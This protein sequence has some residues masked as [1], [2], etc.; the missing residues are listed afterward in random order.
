MATHYTY[1]EL[2]KGRLCQGDVL[3][4]TP[5]LVSLLKKYHSHYADHPDYRYFLVLTQ[6]CDLYRRNGS[7]PASRYITLA[8]VRP[9]EEAIRREARSRQ[10]WWQEPTRVLSLRAFDELVLFTESL[11]NNNIPNYFY[12]HED[13]SLGIS[14][15]HCAFL[16]LSVALKIDHYDLC[17]DSKLAQLKEPFQAKLGWLVGNMYSRIGTEEW[18]DH[19]G[20]ND[21]RKEA[22]ALLK[23][24]FV[25]YRGEQIEKAI[26]SLRSQQKLEEYSPNEILEEVQRCRLIPPQKEFGKRVEAIVEGFRL[27]D[28]VGSRTMEAIRTDERLALQVR[29]LLE[30]ADVADAEAV[31][32]EVLTSISKWVKSAVSD[33]ALPNRSRIVRKLTAAIKGDTL[34]KNL[35]E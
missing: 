33:E 22:A 14:G 27:V 19:Y 17:L 29:Q 34:I 5:Q 15:R 28:S 6:S 10:Q 2:D 7:P 3:R 26:K 12:L 24:T 4:K 31:C 9:I 11:F 32:K 20:R 25:T 8:A 16:A 13:I 35:I 21:A 1:G 23:D 30:D 18:D